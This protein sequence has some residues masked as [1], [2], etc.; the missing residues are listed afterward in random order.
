MNKVCRDFMH[1]RCERGSSCQYIHDIQLC[2]HFWKHGSCKFGNEC[3]KN[4]FINEN[5]NSVHLKTR[6][7][8]VCF[9]PMSQPT[10]M[11]IVY[12]MGT[13]IDKCM[14]RLTTRDVLIVPNLFIDF[15]EGILYKRLLKEMERS[16]IDPKDLFKMWHGN[17]KIEGTHFIADDKTNWKELCPTFEMVID[18]MANFFDMEVKATRFNW[19]AD[20]SQWKPFHH[21]AS[22]V[23]ADKA[24]SQ[25]F[26]V[27][28][29]FGATR[30][31]AFEHAT[32]KTT[33]SMPQRDGCIYAFC[34]DT[35]IIW[36]HG[37]L[38]DMPIRN[39]GRI[40]LICWGYVHNMKQV[41]Q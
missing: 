20:T 26:T 1:N 7:N 16:R 41:S 34:K 5:K 12:D 13:C 36:R 14:T 19:Y 2:F 24:L 4:H 23:K 22:A 17:D 9:E 3:K 29:S 35:N 6:K 15:D 37:I 40:S 8:T 39:L 32:T 18:R 30:D 21:D 10:D 27:A 25:N 38:Q 33:I 31:A 28:V 11:R